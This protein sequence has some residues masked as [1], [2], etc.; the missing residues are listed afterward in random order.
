MPSGNPIY[1]PDIADEII[2]RLE[3]GETLTEICQDE[4][5]PARR[6]VTKWLNDGE[7]AEF[8]ARY[9]RARLIQA[10]SEA[11]DS[12]RIARRIESGDLTPEQGRVLLNIL[13]WRAKVLNPKVY[14]DRQQ[15]AA[16]DADGNAAGFVFGVIA[17]P[18]KQIEDK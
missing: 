4:H 1:T 18:P 16:T 3:S 8:V 15:I 9:A 13:T 12:K 14:G 10:D 7:P 6:T 11:D 2:S 17:S 5:L